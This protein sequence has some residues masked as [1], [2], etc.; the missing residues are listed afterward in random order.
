MAVERISY[1]LFK[2]IIFFVYLTL[3]FSLVTNTGSDEQTDWET[4]YNV[5]I[6]SMEILCALYCLLVVSGAYLS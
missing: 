6:V 3:C 1:L 2:L 4:L 5:S